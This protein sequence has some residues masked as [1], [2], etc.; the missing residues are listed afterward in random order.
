MRKGLRQ[1][2]KDWPIYENTGAFQKGPFLE[3]SKQGLAGEEGR[4][5]GGFRGEMM[6]ELAFGSRESDFI[7]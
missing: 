3:D 7:F 1:C 5:W 6:E 4:V 2:E